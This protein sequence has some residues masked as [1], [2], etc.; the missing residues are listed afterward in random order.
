MN[1]PVRV[2]NKRFLSDTRILNEILSASFSLSLF[3]PLRFVVAF[4]IQSGNNDIVS[5]IRRDGQERRY[6]V[7]PVKRSRGGK[8]ESRGN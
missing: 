2:S 1:Q 3:L 8:K 7:I 6:G 4:Q 5:F